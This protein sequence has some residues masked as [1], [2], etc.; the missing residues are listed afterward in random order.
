MDKV[1]APQPEIL[2]Y[3]SKVT[4]TS[5]YNVNFTIAFVILMAL[6]IIL[7]RGTAKMVS[8]KWSS[9]TVKENFVR[10]GYAIIPSDLT[11]HLAHNLFH[12]LTEGRAIWFNTLSLFTSCITGALALT[13]VQTLQY[14]I[15]ILG[16]I[17][18]SYAVYRVGNK[19][20]WTKLLPYYGA[21][22]CFCSDEHLPIL[23]TKES[24]RIEIVHAYY[25][26]R[27]LFDG[28]SF[29]LLPFSS[30]V[31]SQYHE[32]HNKCI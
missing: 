4:G 10:F 30:A 31:T 18:S 15:A 29:Y 13:S 7:L 9:T 3:Q 23:T 22:G 21:H 19:G 5:N 24:S 14:S 20:S 25:M 28:L 6:P 11:G 16:L 26:K 8:K 1:F 32:R 17:G 27:G 2:G 12:S